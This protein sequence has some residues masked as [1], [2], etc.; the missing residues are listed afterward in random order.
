M[1]ETSSAGPGGRP[2]GTPRRAIRSGRP[3]AGRRGWH[4]LRPD[5]PER[6]NDRKRRNPPGVPEGASAGWSILSYMLGGM[7]LY[8]ALGWLIGRWTGIAVLFPVG[9]L[10]GLGLAITLIILRYGRH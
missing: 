10:V 7:A 9:M 3:P 6:K 4:G 2:P 8:G 5:G 1:S